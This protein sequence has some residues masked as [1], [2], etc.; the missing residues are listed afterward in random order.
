MPTRHNDKDDYRAW[1][2][3]RSRASKPANLLQSSPATGNGPELR[4]IGGTPRVLAYSAPRDRIHL[5]PRPMAH[6]DVTDPGSLVRKLRRSSR[7]RA[8][9]MQGS[10]RTCRWLGPLPP[11]ERRIE[12]PCVFQ[13]LCR[14]HL[15]LHGRSCGQTGGGSSSSSLKSSSSTSWSQ[16]SY[17]GGSGQVR[18]GVVLSTVWPLSAWRAASGSGG[19]R[20]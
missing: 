15:P 18:R 11:G 12:G 3:P 10:P 8:R 9:S 1:Q 7:R 20:G 14:V 5:R 16:F 2:E 17:G 19:V 6:P 4:S 13:F